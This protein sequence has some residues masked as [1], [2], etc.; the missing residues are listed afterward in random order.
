MN[1]RLGSDPSAADVTLDLAMDV[2]LSGLG[3]VRE[4]MHTKGYRLPCPST[5][6]R[7]EGE[8]QA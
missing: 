3:K 7:E 1:P 4:G 6:E 8:V 5:E 2:I